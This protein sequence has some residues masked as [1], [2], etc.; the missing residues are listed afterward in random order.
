[1][2]QYIEKLHDLVW[3]WTLVAVW[4]LTFFN[5][6]CFNQVSLVTYSWSGAIVQTSFDDYTTDDGVLAS[7]DLIPFIPTDHPELL[8]GLRA[9]SISVFQEDGP[10]RADASLVRDVAY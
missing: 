5:H 9:L 1:M 10:R 6:C 8:W 2:Y 3:Q 7:V 4:W